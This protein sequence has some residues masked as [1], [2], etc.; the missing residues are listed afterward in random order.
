M[1]TTLDQHIDVTPDVRNGRPRIS[2]RRITV[3]DIVIMHLRL[4]ESVEQIVAKYDLTFADVHAALTYY[5]DHQAEIDRLIAQDEAVVEAF[6]RD[7]PS[8][9]QEKLKALRDG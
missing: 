2:G 6:Q 7:N 8:R 3:D 1:A 9:L 4:G 5:Y